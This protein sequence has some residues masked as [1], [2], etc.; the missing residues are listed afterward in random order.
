MKIAMLV[1]YPILPPDE[2][3]RRRAV[4]LLTHLARE[5]EMLLLTP[6]SPHHADHAGDLPARVIETGAPGRLR[7]VASPALYRRLASIIRDERPDVVV[8]EFPWGGLHAALL[9]RRHHLPFVLDAHNVEGDRFRATRSRS[10]PLVAL[11]ERIVARRAARVWCVS[12][13]DRERFLALGVPPDRI[14][15]VPNGVDPQIFHPGP[16]AGAAIRASLG[17]APSMKMLL[18]FGQLDYPPNR[19]ALAIIE[20]EIAPR[21]SGDY[22]IIV[23][24]KGVP[25]S[26]PGALTYVGPVPAITP[27]INAADAVIAPLTAGGGTRLK[28]LESIACGTPVVST[29][30]GAEGIDPAACAPLLTLAGDWTAFVDAVRHVSAA[31]DG[32]VPAAF[33]DM[34]SWANIAKRARFPIAG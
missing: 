29:A 24:G 10:A 11:L 27:Y 5:H 15:V 2:G 26:G 6:A 4:S 28:V 31:K 14:D 22:R 19:D 23:A 30:A 25:A 8:L 32:N 13:H 21:L 33:L 34:Y 12:D 9:A 17:I 20:Q 3:G 18:F 16:A 7:Q 1:P